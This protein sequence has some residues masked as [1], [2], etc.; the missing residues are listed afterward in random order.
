MVKSH[1]I[2]GANGR[3]ARSLAAGEVGPAESAAGNK[4]IVVVIVGPHSI[5]LVVIVVI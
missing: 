4:S 3:L 1:E 2:R 5:N